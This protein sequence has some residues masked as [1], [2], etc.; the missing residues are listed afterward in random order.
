MRAVVTDELIEFKIYIEHIMNNTINNGMGMYY[1]V[2]IHK[3]GVHVTLYHS[4]SIINIRH[5]MDIST[6]RDPRYIKAIITDMVTSLAVKV[7]IRRNSE[8]NK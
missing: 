1:S 6:P 7:Y 5:Y 4:K 8:T 3:E 2:K